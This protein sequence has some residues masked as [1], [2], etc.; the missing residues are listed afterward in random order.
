VCGGIGYVVSPESS[1]TFW[2]KDI[3]NSSRAGGLL[4]ISNQNL[5]SALMRIAHGPV[6]LKILLPVTVAV[7]ALGLALAV[8]AY[9]AS[10]PLL[11]LI[12]CATTGLVVSPIT[13]SHHLVWVV[14]AILWVALARD[15]PAHGRKLAAVMAVFFWAGPI[16]WVPKSDRGLHEKVW[17]LV[18][19]D[20]F[21]WVMLAF[22]VAVAVLLLQ[23]R[24]V[25]PAAA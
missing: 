15:R 1:R 16:W 5:K 7:G 8:W 21:L 17:E 10:S 24:P 14:P 18:V 12:V 23:R 25:N 13:W 2:T 6:P 3:F 19:G 22:L 9:R 20:S 4:S 11:G